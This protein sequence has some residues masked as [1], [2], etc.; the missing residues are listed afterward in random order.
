[1]DFSF[2][3]F[4]SDCSSCFSSDFFATTLDSDSVF[5]SFDLSLVSVDAS[6][7]SSSLDSET[8]FEDSVFSAWFVSCGSSV[9]V[10]VSTS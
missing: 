2:L 3:S 7:V 9:D 6:S 5:S 8:S 1:L 4:D 10:C